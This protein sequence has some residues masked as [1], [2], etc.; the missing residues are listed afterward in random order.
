MHLLGTIF[1]HGSGALVGIS[2]RSTVYFGISQNNNVH[3]V[4]CNNGYRCCFVF[5]FFYKDGQFQRY[6][7]QFY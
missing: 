7:K 3:G 4:A 6:D 5:C 1:S 2:I